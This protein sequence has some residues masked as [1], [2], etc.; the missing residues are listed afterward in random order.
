MSINYI[1]NFFKKRQ[2]QKEDKNNKIIFKRKKDQKLIIKINFIEKI[3]K[4]HILT[5]I[6]ILMLLLSMFVNAFLKINIVEIT[7]NDNI[8]NIS[9]AYKSIDKFRWKYLFM[10][11]DVDIENAI[12]TNQ[13]NIKTIKIT[14]LPTNTLKIE[15][16]SY[17]PIFKTVFNDK[18]YIII[19][20]WVFI[21]SS[22]ENKTL[23]KINLK[24]NKETHFPDYKIIVSEKYL[25]KIQSLN[26]KI[27]K[28][29][30]NLK[31][32][33]LDYY[34]IERELHIIDLNW[35]RIIFD[36]EWDLDKQVKRLSIFNKNYFDLTKIG[37]IYID[38][39]INNK[40]FYC[41][42]W[43]KW[44]NNLTCVNNLTNIYLN[45]K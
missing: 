19:S 23:N 26:D 45:K 17:E 16:E 11:K 20:N 14:K 3:K 2:I 40:I 21:P 37:M 29:I 25:K 1:K 32:K 22:N 36:L 24:T 43:E 12:R 9:I 38:L 28:N 4:S 7:K 13:K 35:A 44:I 33:E 10:V 6:L 39:R 5:F 41:A 18:N 31:I 27:F 30:T 34:I 42:S 8:T 15:L